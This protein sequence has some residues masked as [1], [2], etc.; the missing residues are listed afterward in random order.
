M[1]SILSKTAA[2]APREFNRWRVVP[3][4]VI[5]HVSIGGLYAWSMLNEPISRALGVVSSIPQD[6]GLS[7]IV[8]VFS[9]AVFFAGATAAA[10]GAWSDKMGPRPSIFLSGLFWGGGLALGGLG[11]NLHQLGL[12]YLG[13]GVLGGT[14]IGFAYGP[15]VATLLRWFPDRKGKGYPP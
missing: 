5:T 6:W 12:V 8:P 1:L 9:T 13:Y 4:A 15:P 11:V 2:T 10:S 3:P 14:G 7:S